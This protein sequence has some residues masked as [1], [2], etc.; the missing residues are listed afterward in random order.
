[1]TLLALLAT[2]L[3]HTPSPIPLL[4]LLVLIGLALWTIQAT[5]RNK[6]HRHL[7]NEGWTPLFCAMIISSGTGMVLEKFV[8]RYEGY[9]LMAVVIGGAC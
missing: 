2:L 5:L 3:L 7:L 1:M 9:A 6:D 4:L 8:K